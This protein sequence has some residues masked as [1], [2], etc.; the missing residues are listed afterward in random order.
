MTTG[1]NL[2]RF[3]LIQPFQ[4][5]VTTRLAN[6]AN[7]WT[8]APYNGVNPYPY[9]IGGTDEQLRQIPFTE[10]AGFSSFHEDFFTP[11]NQQ[12]DLSFSMKSPETI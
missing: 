11:Y 5:Q 9:P 4:L 12:W 6:I 7:P 3:M 8:P 10:G 1:I 2:N